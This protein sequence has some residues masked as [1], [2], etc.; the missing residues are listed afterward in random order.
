MQTRFSDFLSRLSLFAV[1]AVLP[2]GFVHAQAITHQ[3]SL[4]NGMTWCDDSMINGLFTQVNA[5]RAQNNVALLSMNTLGMKDA[6]LRAVQFAVYMQTNSPGTPGF[7]PH[8][9]YDT[10]AASIGYSIV[11]ENLAY[12]TTDPVYIVTGVWQDPLHLAAMLSTSANVAGVSCV[13]Y[14]GTPYWTYEPGSCTGTS[15]SSTPTPGGTPTVDSEE[16]NFLTLI[17]NYRAQ[18]GAGPLQVSVDLENSSQWMSNDM[19][20]NNYASHTDS[21]GRDPGTRLAAFGYTYTPWGENIAGG[22]SDA[23]DTFTQWMYACDPDTSGNCTYAHRKNMLYAGFNVIGIARS[24]SSSSAY[25]WY[26][27][28]DFGGYVDQTITPPGSSG[29]PAAVPVI[30]SFTGAPSTIASGQAALLSWTVSGAT[31]LSI[32]NGVGDVSTLTSKSV[33]PLQTTT[34]TL[35]AT[36]SAGNATTSVTIT[37]SAAKDTQP[38]STPTLVSATP[39]TATEVDLSW[40][41]STDNV[42][43]AGYQI[44]RNGAALTSVSGTALAYADTSASA[45]ATYA[46]AVKAFDA[47][48]NY[49]GASNTINATTPAA[50]PPA[51]SCPGPATGS[52]TG[53]YYT[54]I[55]LSGSPALVR[56]DS[57]INFDWGSSSPDPS[58]PA[59]DFSVRWQG[60]F[61]FTA[62]TYSISAMT[63]DGMRVYID[64]NDVVDRWHDQPIALYRAQ[65]TLTQ[66]VHL[67][68]V[69][70]YEHTGWSSAHVSWQNTAPTTPPP[71]ILSFTATPS[72]I[73]AGQRSTLAWSVTGATTVVI[74]QGVGD[75]SNLTSTSVAATQTTTYTLTASNSGGS[76]TAPATVTVS[77][78][79]DTQPPS[80]PTLSSANAATSSQ[81]NLAWTASTDNVG[82][83]GYQIL[84]NGTALGSVTG[85]ALT[86]SDTNVSPST[87]Y[88]YTVKAYD[89]AGNYSAASN[90]ITATTPAAPVSS[91]SCG[92]PASGSF[93]GCYYDNTTLSGTPALV[94]TDAQIN[95]DW[96]AGSPSPALTP[97]NF[98]VRWQGY[99]NFDAGNYA[100]G[101]IAPTG[102]R[103]CIDGN[104]VLDRW[105]N[106]AGYFMYMA[107]QTLSQGSHL[108]GL[109]YRETPGSTGVH[110]SWQNY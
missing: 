106:T 69:E 63:S 38:P 68:T 8:Q 81:V 95:F 39:K 16:W 4:S 31:T 9:G 62:G 109:E 19:A 64:G 32:D 27:V 61:T 28:T 73:S 11:S 102:V 30:T 35:T 72:T 85:G 90:A 50:P 101:V 6:E 108:I 57:Q 25:G 71:S 26:W 99:F 47:A 88:T 10:T 98:S 2:A 58:I 86:Y 17:N 48:G 110:L 36:N 51:A 66:G 46:Y 15:C 70:Y 65:Q 59:G 44:L 74:D 41:A 33:A 20:T 79:N 105:D 52:F 13:Y 104:L 97:G 53:C 45:N 42:G 78:A 82:V 29:T 55:D 12:I 60:N 7:N 23:Q 43:V 93:T 56:T 5:F 92:A 77:T 14:N 75:V 40:T 84:R 67:I 18:N 34:Y 103:L 94:R 3:I 89:A 83:A 80:I 21:L 22:Y 54:N 91:G 24:Y 107:Y 1:L 76:V 49:S 37:V 87:S 96:G 100:F